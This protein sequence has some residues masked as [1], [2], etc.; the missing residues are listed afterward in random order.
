MLWHNNS[1]KIDLQEDVLFI[2]KKMHDFRKK[3]ARTCETNTVRPFR[4]LQSSIY[5]WNKQV[6]ISLSFHLWFNQM[7][8]TPLIDN[9]S[10]DLAQN[11]FKV[12]RLIY[13]YLNTIYTLISFKTL[14]YRHLPAIDI[15]QSHFF[16]L[17]FFRIEHRKRKKKCF[18]LNQFE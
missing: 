15:Y 11:L 12:F 7:L 14:K 2:L 8:S 10:C 1:D 9:I 3:I 16:H 4:W 5:W 18:D 17:D 6:F 13:Q